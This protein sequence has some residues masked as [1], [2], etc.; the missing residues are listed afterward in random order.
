M[1]AALVSG[2]AAQ[3]FE[4]LP[5]E[6][7]VA[8]VM[9]VLRGWYSPRGISVPEPLQV[10][11]LRLRDMPSAF[12]S[13]FCTTLDPDS[14]TLKPALCAPAYCWHATSILTLLENIRVGLRGSWEMR[15]WSGSF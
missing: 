3:R 13:Y 2:A 14:Q 1:L 11:C 6:A 9:A 8:E 7:A 12:A 5:L 4:E 15:P 10:R